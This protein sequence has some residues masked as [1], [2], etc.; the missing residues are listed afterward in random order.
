MAVTDTTYDGLFKDRYVGKLETLLP[1]TAIVQ[2]DVRFNAA[3]ALGDEYVKNLRVKRSASFTFYGSALDAFALAAINTGGTVAAKAKGSQFVLR[4]SLSYGAIKNAKNSM[5][6]FGNAFDETVKDMVEAAA[7]ALELQLLYGNSSI[8]EV[9][10]I[11][12]GATTTETAT[13]T[14]ASWAMGIWAQ[15][16]GLEVDVYDAPGGTKVNTNAAI[17]VGVVDHSARTVELT[18][19]ATDLAAISGSDVIIPRDADGQWSSGLDILVP[20]TSGTMHGVSLSTY[21]AMRGNSVSAGSASLSFTTVDAAAATINARS[22]HHRELSLYVSPFTFTDLNQ[23]LSAL[24][25]YTANEATGKLGYQAIEY[26]AQTGDITVKSHPMVKAGEAFLVNPEGLERVG[27]TDT[28]FDAADAMGEGGESKFVTQLA[29]N[30]GV[31]LR[32]YWNQGLMNTRAPSH[33][34]I[35]GIVNDSL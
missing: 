32:C 22:G 21:G 4:D 8:G 13:I 5:Q 12:S 31:E 16:E 24:R 23:D 35:T 11:T 30:A 20:Q 1:S 2:D 34:K 14:E 26:T 28:T 6:A 9:A 3:D 18:G 33:C 19:N 27:S 25:R 10:S 15:A 29:S 7:F 17:S